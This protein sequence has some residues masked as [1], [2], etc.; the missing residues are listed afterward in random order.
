MSARAFFPRLALAALTLAAPGCDSPSPGCT[1]AG[2]RAGTCQIGDACVDSLDCE[3]SNCTDGHCAASCTS[4]TDC[5]S[6]AICVSV[7][8]GR[9]TRRSCTSTC[10]SEAFHVVGDTGGLAC[11]DGVLRACSELSDPGPV[12][13]LCRCAVGLRCVLPGGSEC[14]TATS[15]CSC[16]A[17]GPVGAPCTSNVTCL[18]F[19]CSGVPGGARHCQIPAGQACDATS[20]CL[21]C[22]APNDAGETSCRQSCERD[23]DC[24]GAVCVPGTAGEPACYADCTIDGHCPTG[25]S[26][27]P[28][29]GDPR[30][31][32]Y[33]A[34]SG[35]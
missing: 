28:F 4:A 26:C 8:D 12:C 16:V 18:S 20:D 6:G 23:A 32:R 35:V 33:C 25:E 24:M 31:R 30:A 22:D 1:S 9:G 15:P 7:H 29:E 10:P 21:H 27:V 14:R 11:V 3:S 34:P 13:D 5:P 2:G 19:N 17:P